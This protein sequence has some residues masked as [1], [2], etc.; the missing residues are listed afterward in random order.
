[1]SNVSGTGKTGNGNPCEQKGVIRSR[2]GKLVDWAE[3]VENAASAQDSIRGTDRAQSIP[4]YK[5]T[6]NDEYRDS[7]SNAHRIPAALVDAHSMIDE[8][9]AFLECTRSFGIEDDRLAERAVAV[10]AALQPIVKGRVWL[11]FDKMLIDKTLI[12]TEALTVTSAVRAA[13]EQVKDADGSPSTAAYRWAIARAFRDDINGAPTDRFGGRVLTNG[14]GIVLIREEDLRVS[15]EPKEFR[16]A[17]PPMIGSNLA[18]SYMSG[19]CDV[20][21]RVLGTM[22]MSGPSNPLLAPVKVRF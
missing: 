1:M 9:R 4:G 8:V 12:A 13:L 6:P 19:A 7:Y 16:A 15:D 3:V 21:A 2:G 20:F 17:A 18:D 14:H 10:R 22:A 11:V 5:A